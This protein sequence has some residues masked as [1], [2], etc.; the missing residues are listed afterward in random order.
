MAFIHAPH[1][2]EAGALIDAAARFAVPFFFLTAG[3]FLP[4]AFPSLLTAAARILGRL[5]VPWLVWSVVYWLIY[6]QLGAPTLGTRA[7]PH[8]WFLP[9]LALCMLIAV[10]FS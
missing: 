1:V 8:L 10:L 7:A 3:Y 9:A 5:L 4:S 6:D 2:G